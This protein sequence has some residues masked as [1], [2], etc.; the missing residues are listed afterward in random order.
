LEKAIII[1]NQSILERLKESI[2]GI[3]INS[4]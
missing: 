3:F 4:Y 2:E 1:I